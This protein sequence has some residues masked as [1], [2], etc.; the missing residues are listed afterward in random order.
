MS[1]QLFNMLAPEK[2]LQDFESAHKDIDIKIFRKSFRK[3]HNKMN[4]IG[5]LDRFTEYSSVYIPTNIRKYIP[6]KI[7]YNNRECVSCQVST[8]IPEC[9]H[10]DNEWM[11]VKCQDLLAMTDD[12]VYY[13][14][15][16]KMNNIITQE[17]AFTTS[18]YHTEPLKWQLSHH[19]D[20]SPIMPEDYPLETLQMIE[21]FSSL[22]IT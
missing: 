6:T 22:T 19:Q 20:P 10:D 8:S 12:P 15:C 11:C 7:K 14:E 17:S 18:N 13:N 1:Y 2:D 9:S 3:Y 21:M 4:L 16:P 5:S